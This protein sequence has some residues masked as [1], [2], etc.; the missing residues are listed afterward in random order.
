MLVLLNSAV[1]LSIYKIKIKR[2]KE[3][4]SETEKGK[5]NKNQSLKSCNLL[6]MQVCFNE[7]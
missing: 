7:Q 4:S 1:C 6:G 2:K 3:S 5:K